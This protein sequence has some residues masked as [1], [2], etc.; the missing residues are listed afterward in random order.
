MVAG[1]WR[2]RMRVLLLHKLMLDQLQVY[3][4][5]LNAPLDRLCVQNLAKILPVLTSQ[6]CMYN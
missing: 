4:V 3:R 1:C 2:Q 5:S 6:D